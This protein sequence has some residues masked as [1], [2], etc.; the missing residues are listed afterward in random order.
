MKKSENATFE[1]GKVLDNK[2]IIIELIGKGAM[3]EVYRAH[4]TN[5]KR[6]VAIKI[7]SDDVMVEIED[8]P[9]E[10]GV[11]FG[12]FQREVQTMAQVRHTNILTIFDYGEI[13]EKIGSE[14]SRIAYIVME[15]IPGN[16]LRFTLSEDGLDDIPDVYGKWIGDYFMP[17]MD[18]VEILHNNNIIHRDLKPENV[19]MDGAVPKIADFGLARSVHMKA[20]TTS[21]EMLGTLAYMSPEQCSDFKTAD[22][23]TDI[24]ALGKMLFEA[25]HGTLTEKVVPFTSVAIDNPQ[26]VFLEE[27]SLII[28]KATAEEPGARY[29]TIQELR[30]DLKKALLMIE[31]GEKRQ[32]EIQPTVGRSLNFASAHITWVLVGVVIAIISV[33][34]MGIYHLFVKQ[35]SLADLDASPYTE[36]ADLL[37]EK[38]I[39]ADGKEDLLQN[40][41]GMDGSRMIFTGTVDNGEEFPLFYMDEQKIT[42][43]LFVEFLN[44]LSE[45]LSVKEGMVRHG[46]TIII[47]IGS[48]SA[49]EDSIVYRHG[50]FHLKDQRDGSK[51]VVRVTYHGAHMFAANYGKE[52][53][54]D[55]EWEYAYQYHSENIEKIDL[56]EMEPKDNVS[57]NMM[58]STTV[59][60]IEKSRQPEP[61][62]DNM[63]RAFK[64]WVRITPAVKN[65][66]TAHPPD[67]V[68]DSGVLDA[69]ISNEGAQPLK[70]FPWEG[71]ADVGF[72]TKISIINK[73][74]SQ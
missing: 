50:R 19:F 3:G 63:G 30:T 39:V 8:D 53:L 48:G 43:F 36:H 17:I 70:R 60:K 15:Y 25:V 1:P 58:H 42:N 40:I 24:Y 38:P 10:I 32:Q 20:V 71:F 51:P 4:Q 65:G 7:I 33:A 34:S 18:G 45:N 28:Q 21:I 13:E 57:S 44:I 22:Y 27:M 52:L 74:I 16:S 2:W 12:R 29:Q 72:R 47:Y 35:D 68:Y 61:V 73:S 67:D 31:A 55:K 69:T 64:E 5:L 54:T 41:I 26:T 66:Q 46:D 23:T 9:D 49:E 59:A 14:T 37:D 11:A 62:L 56:V 6:D